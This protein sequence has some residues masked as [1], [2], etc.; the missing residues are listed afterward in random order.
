MWGLWSW[1]ISQWY[2]FLLNLN[3]ED[4]IAF[5]QSTGTHPNTKQD[6]IILLNIER[7]R[8]DPLCSPEISHLALMSRKVWTYL[9]PFV[10]THRKP[11]P[12]PAASWA[13][14]ATVNMAA[15]CGES[16]R[17]RE[18]VVIPPRRLCRFNFPSQDCL[19]LL[20]LVP[21]FHRT[22]S[23]IRDCNSAL[24]FQ[25]HGIPRVPAW[26]FKSVWNEIEKSYKTNSI[27]CFIPQSNF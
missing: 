25:S 18:A 3:D 8:S 21:S 15:R 2:N 5:L 9:L 20:Q 16:E 24:C 19:L 10:W 26:V 17:P 27:G 14:Q 1:R 4:N 23:T 22:S 11:P 6:W 7:I 13:R 12:Q